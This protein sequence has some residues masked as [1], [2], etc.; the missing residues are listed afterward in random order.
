MLMCVICGSK[1]PDSNGD[2]VNEDF[3][4]SCLGKELEF[5]NKVR[6]YV[7]MREGLFHPTKGEENIE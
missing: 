7:E 6:N 2:Y 4:E 3:C 5:L 1:R